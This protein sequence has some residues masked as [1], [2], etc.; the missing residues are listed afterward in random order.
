MNRI[1]EAYQP[2][3]ENVIVFIYYSGAKRYSHLGDSYYIM[4]DTQRRF[5]NQLSNAIKCL[6]GTIYIRNRIPA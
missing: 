2:I 5:I 3:N 4:T 1:K 6:D